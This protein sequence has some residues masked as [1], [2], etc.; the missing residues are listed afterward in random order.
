MQHRYSE[1]PTLARLRQAVPVATLMAVSFRRNVICTVLRSPFL[2]R[3]YSSQQEKTPVNE[4]LNKKG[5]HWR[6]YQVPLPPPLY[7]GRVSTGGTQGREDDR[8][9]AQK[10]G[11][12]TVA[13]PAKHGSHLSPTSSPGWRN[14]AE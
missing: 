14:V 8:R 1:R 4:K 13:R 3:A 10:L 2:N 12:G 7:A 5:P 11:V 9:D 6:K